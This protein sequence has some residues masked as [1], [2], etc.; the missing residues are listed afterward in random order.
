M[1]RYLLLVPFLLLCCSCGKKNFYADTQVTSPAEYHKLLTAPNSIDS[2]TVQA[3]SHYK[4]SS[5]YE[6]LWGARHRSSWATPVT[7]PILRLDTVKGGLS[8]EKIGGGMQT[9]SATLVSS[10]GMTYALRTVDKRPELSLPA[11]LRHTFIAD[12]VLDQ[13]AS[14][15]PYAPL[16]VAPLSEAVGVPHANPVLYYV[17]P[18]DTAL[19][20]HKELLS[21]RL[22]TLE[23]KY[24]DA[25]AL[26]GNL[27]AAYTIVGTKEMF[28]RTNAHNSHV[29]DPMAYAKARLLDLLIGD[30]DRHEDQWE[31]AVFREGN[32]HVYRPLPKDRDNAFFMYDDGLLSWLFSRKWAQRKFVSFHGN[33][34]DVKGLMLK[35][36]ELDAGILPGVTAQQ[37]DSLAREMQHHL[38]DQVI[39]A[40]VRR[41]PAAVYQE[42]GPTLALKL[43]SRRDALDEATGTFYRVLAEEVEIKGTDD[44]ERFEITGINERQVAIKVQ[45]VAD[46]AVLYQRTFRYPETEEITL[47]G[48]GGNDVFVVLGQG[49]NKFRIAIKGGDGEDSLTSATDDGN[50]RKKGTTTSVEVMK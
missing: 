12:L 43:K 35:S 15:Q 5:F 26:R 4:R 6:L 32:R 27:A 8:V 48:L 41:L 28:K 46:G 11:V 7:V 30:R 33:Y 45:S 31:W 19:Q 42:Y 13:T 39:E 44:P 49:K 1:T 40:A 38:T 25:R 29:V 9:I 23:E 10:N 50:R 16:V 17:I 47:R 2:V 36:E 18:N 22:Y 3:G 34:H 14:L 21:G 37:F 24:S 20:H